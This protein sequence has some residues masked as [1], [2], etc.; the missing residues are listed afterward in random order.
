MCFVVCFFSSR[1]R[2]TRCALVTGVQ[3]CALPIF[4]CAGQR[5]L[6]IGNVDG[7]ARGG[8]PLYRATEQ[9]HLTAQSL[10]RSRRIVAGL[11][12]IIVLV[13]QPPLPGQG[14]EHGRCRPGVSATRALS[15]LGPCPYNTPHTRLGSAAPS[16]PTN[17][18]AAAPDGPS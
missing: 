10:E 11:V 17:T 9:R 15:C 6:V 7:L 2:H 1:R 12:A 13:H 14:P 4:L 3:T 5:R 8:Q 18:T 16:H